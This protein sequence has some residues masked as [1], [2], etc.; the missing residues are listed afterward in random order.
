MSRTWSLSFLRCRPPSWALCAA[1]TSLRSAQMQ[2]TVAG[3]ANLG[4]LQK[5]GRHFMTTLGPTTVD[6]LV[7]P[8]EVVQ[9]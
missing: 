7:Y 4:V 9:L 5:G 3:L 6:L 1:T 2:S 8:V